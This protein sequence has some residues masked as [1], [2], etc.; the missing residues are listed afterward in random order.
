M[1]DDKKEGTTTIML[2]GFFPFQRFDLIIQSATKAA[3]GQSNAAESNA[4]TGLVQPNEKPPKHDHSTRDLH[5]GAGVSS[6]PLPPR[7]R[8]P[9]AFKPA[10]G[11]PAAPPAPPAPAPG[12]PGTMP[13]GN[14]PP[15]C[16]CCMDCCICARAWTF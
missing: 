15:R 6:P 9:K 11:S 12:I 4:P 7:L 8:L 5:R 1:L 14:T 2:C 13:G 16:S 10:I 3:H